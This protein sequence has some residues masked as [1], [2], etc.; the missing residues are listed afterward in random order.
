M[1]VKTIQHGREV[2]KRLTSPLRGYS[3]NWFVLDTETEAK[4]PHRPSD[5][6]VIGRTQIKVI[7]LCRLGESYT[8]PTSHIGSEFPVTQ[9]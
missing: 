7:S 4:P 5:A 3:V 8:F 2:L 1:V 9:E 6:L